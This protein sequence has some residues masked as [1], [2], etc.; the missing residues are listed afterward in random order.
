MTPN[1]FSDGGEYDSP[2]LFAQKVE[3]M[4][5]LCE[6]LDFGAESTAPFNDAIGKDEE[7]S[8][9]SLFEEID[10]SLF[11]EINFSIDTY[12]PESFLY[13]YR[14]W[15]DRGGRGQLIWND[16]S[17]KLDDSV[18]TVLKE[19]PEV[20]YVYSHNLAPSR[21]LTSSHMDYCRENLEFRDIRVFFAD[22]AGEF[23]DR[24]IFDPCF[25]FS[26]TKDQNLSILHNIEELITNENESWLIGISRKS[27]L[28]AQIQSE[29]KIDQSEFLHCLYLA[30]I[31]QKAR[32]K[33]LLLRIHDPYIAIRAINFLHLRDKYS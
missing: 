16:V 17:G 33:R 30:E 6:W 18:R 20:N 29:N 14:L 3:Q 21:E 26:K 28:Q 10:S 19:C 9:F 24:I 27:F 25:G 2:F 15:K 8:R 5:P 31:L 4:A 12:R 13:F 1:S 32:C 23:I 11:K 7:Q 22:S